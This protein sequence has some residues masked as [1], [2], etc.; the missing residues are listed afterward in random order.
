IAVLLTDRHGGGVPGVAVEFVVV[1]GGGSVTPASAQ[2]DA[3]GRA[4][5]AW[6]FGRA[7]GLNAVEARVVGRSLAP[8]VFAAKAK[9]GP[10]ARLEKLA[11]DAQQGAAASQLPLPLVVRV[12]D[13]NGNPVAGASVAWRCTS[14]GSHAPDVSVTDV[15]GEARATWMLGPGAGVQ[16]MEAR[17]EGSEAAPVQFSANAGVGAAARLEKVSGDLQEAV[18]T[19]QLPQ[20]IVV[21]V[22][23]APGNPLPGV[24]VSWKLF[25]GGG[26]V[27]PAE[28]VTDAQGYAR[29][30]WTL[31]TI[32]AHHRL[33]VR[34]VDLALPP[35]TF[36]ALAR[37]GP[38]AGVAAFRGD[39]GGVPVGTTLR[40]ELVARVTDAHGNPV[41]GVPVAWSGGS[42]LGGFSRTEPATDTLG[43]ARALWAAGTTAGEDEAAASIAGASARFRVRALPGPAATLR[44][45]PRPT[46]LQ[47]TG[48]RVPLGGSTQLGVTAAD[49]F[50]NA[51]PEPTVRWTSS[52]PGVATVSPSGLAG[53]VSRGL[54]VIRAESGHAEDTL[55]V[56][57]D[58]WQRYRVTDL[59]RRLTPLTLNDR[60]Q[61]VGYVTEVE[62]EYAVLWDNGRL[63]EIGRSL[64]RP[65]KAA[66][67]NERGEV[68]GSYRQ[69]FPSTSEWRT[70][71]V[72]FRWQAGQIVATLPHR[73]RNI[74]GLSKIACQRTAVDI[75]E[76]GDV[77]TD[78]GVVWTY[79]GT[80]ELLTSQYFNRIWSLY[81]V[82][83]SD[84]GR[85]AATWT[86]W[87]DW[88]SYE[89]YL[90]RAVWWS[91][92]D[93]TAI[94]PFD[95][96]T[97]VS[98]V[99]GRGWVVGSSR[100][101][102]GWLQRDGALVWISGPRAVPGSVGSAI[103]VN[104]RG[105]VLANA[106]GYFVWENGRA[107][108]V[109]MVGYSAQS[110][111]F[112]EMN[113]VGQ[114]IGDAEVDGVQR[115]ILLTPVP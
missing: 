38:A 95:D 45:V 72:A 28:S 81:G 89:P 114:I 71:N 47:P 26:T 16:A 12:V 3:Q 39:G 51:V 115:G 19:S 70:G 53:G 33:E 44:I 97:R 29:A 107:T 54:A 31:G 57:V 61:V 104:D 34:A 113:N 52:Q 42:R 80:L 85:V 65:S 75:N 55:T 83:I 24:K 98:D 4:R 15:A 5:G 90:T 11:G 32:M 1:Q 105:Q 91:V 68:A 101:G 93:T 6:T 20:P 99:S 2:T 14:G 78:E 43:L 35:L 100:T 36:T 50:G 64:P 37:V 103:S 23:D 49:E 74:L 60:G 48:V 8:A 94:V 62:G 110:Y 46:E 56:D 27:A 66:A 73:C 25:Y 63:V 41:P 77:L 30:T 102:G 13:A 112:R 92:T 111:R 69:T 10:P 59:G 108:Y 84:D 109:D 18:V 22:V 21:R 17:V 87:T 82:G 88:Y 40:V 86:S 7:A 76:R 67:I 106:G 96:S 9:V 79:T 58:R